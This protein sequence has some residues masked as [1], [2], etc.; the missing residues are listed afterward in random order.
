[1]S[2]KHM[3]LLIGGVVVLLVAIALFY[4]LFNAKGRYVAESDSLMA[5]QSRLQ[6]LSTRAVFPSEANVQTMGKQLH[7]YQEYLDSLYAAMREG[8]PPEQALDRDGFRKMLEDTLRQL[9]L[10]ARAKSVVIA[11]TLAFGVQRYIEGAPPA[12]EDLPRL[13]DQLRSIAVLCNILFEAGIG[14]LVS[15]DRTVFEKDAQ[16]VPVEEGY[17]A[18]RGQSDKAAPPPP[19]TELYRDP[20]GLFTKEHYVLSYRAQDAANWKILD[21]LAQGA[22]F[23]VVTRMEITNP[24]RPPAVMPKTEDAAPAAARP[25]ST[26]GW[27]SAAPQGSAPAEKK[28]TEILPRELRVVAGQELPNVRLEVDLYRFAEAAAEKGENP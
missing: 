7:I 20:D 22:P 8:Q 10:T 25:T 18:R 19:S 28:E 15:V 14:E 26:A 27:Q 5:V 23:V 24:S 21:R 17:N 12:D 16:V 4:A 9:G 6:R 13:T 11:P 1:M 3:P 2:R